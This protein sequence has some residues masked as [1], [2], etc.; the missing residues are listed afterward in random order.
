MEPSKQTKLADK[1]KSKRNRLLM[2]DNTLSLNVES[3]EAAN[4]SDAADLEVVRFS[5]SN[6]YY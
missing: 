3:S 5:N 1:L 6:S 4:P 2:N